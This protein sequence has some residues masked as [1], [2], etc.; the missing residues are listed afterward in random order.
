MLYPT[1]ATIYMASR[2]Q[3][4]AEEAI[5]TIVATDPSG[6]SRLRFLQID[7]ND[8][9][10]V[11]AAA[12]SFQAQESRLDVLWNNAG[13]GA[14]AVGTRTEQGI[15]ADMGVNVIAPLLLTELLMPQLKAA[16]VS[17]AKASVRVVWT[18]SWMMEGG[19]PKGGY[20]MKVLEA[21]G[22]KDSTLNYSTSKAA[23]FMI[24]SEL[25]KR[26]GKDGIISVCQNPGNLDTRIYD[27]QSKF[28]MFFARRILLHPQKMGAYTEL[29]AGLSGE[30]EEKH[31][32]A[33]VIPWGRVQER[34]PR[35]DIYE[36][37]KQ[38]KGKELWDWCFKQIQ[39][40]E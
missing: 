26:Y 19:A 1:G 27:T 20:D 30:I 13:I 37:I 39:A 32:G 23:N 12:R 6:V 17:A 28:V 16:A 11:R 33:Y 36:A 31:Q 21:G 24:S 34:N 15:E 10:S 25:G 3:S 22:T 35:E 29:F 2:T 38:G 40:H 9:A 7:L 4:K 14:V 5:K 18:G 8:L